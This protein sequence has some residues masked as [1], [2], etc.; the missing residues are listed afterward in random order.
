MKHKDRILLE[1]AYDE[2]TRESNELKQ[3]VLEYEA[4]FKKYPNIAIDVS[5]EN[6]LYAYDRVSNPNDREYLST[7]N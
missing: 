7:N 4:L 2:V 6:E 5:D 3:F 1:Q